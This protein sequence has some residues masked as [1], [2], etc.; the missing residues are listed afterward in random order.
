M[1]ESRINT[2][3]PE[4][5]RIINP[6][7]AVTAP[8]SQAPRVKM[9]WGYKKAGIPLRDPAYFEKENCQLIELILCYIRN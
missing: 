8:K 4:Q 6:V 5:H 7:T 2:R 1:N 9:G 3:A